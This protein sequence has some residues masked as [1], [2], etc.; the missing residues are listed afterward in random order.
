MQT[1]VG[2]FCDRLL[3]ASWLIAAVATPLFLSSYAPRAFDAPKTVLI[4]GLA[5]LML[6][7]WL[8]KKADAE[9]G[10][11]VAASP[12]LPISA[13][14]PVL[15]AVLLGT[16]YCAATITSIAPRLSLW[17]SYQRLQGTYTTLSYIVIFLLTAYHLRR[18]EQVQRLVTAI[19][20]SSLPVCFFGLAQ[21]FNLDPI[22]W[23]GEE[24][25]G[26]FSTLGHPL[27][28]AGYL[29]MVIPLTLEHLAQ[30][31]KNPVTDSFTR[32]RLIPAIALTLLLGLQ[33]T[34]F[35]LT[36]SRGPTLGLAAG[37]LVMFL[38]WAYT[39]GRRNLAFLTLG[40]GLEVFLLVILL[41]LPNTPFPGA[42]KT[43]ERLPYL[44]RI[45]RILET[46]GGSGGFRLVLWDSTVQLMASDPA[47]LALGY[48]PETYAITILPYY[49]QNLVSPSSERLP[50]RAHN[51]TF[52]ILT[53]TGLLGLLAHLLL[54]GGVFYYGVH[55][56]GIASTRHQRMALSGT[57]A[58]AV[59]AGGLGPRAITGGWGLSGLGVS[60]GL[61]AGCIF[62]LAVR[63]LT[64]RQPFP[65]LRSP[66]AFLSALLAAI[67]AHLIEISFGIAIP[68]TRLYFWLFAAAIVSPLYAVVRQEAPVQV[69]AATAQPRAANQRN[70]T[71]GGPPGLLDARPALATLLALALVTLAFGLVDPYQFNLAAHYF[72]L[73]LLILMTWITG[74]LMT[75][76]GVS[77]GLPLHNVQG[78]LLN[79]AKGHAGK[80]VWLNSAWL[81]WIIAGGLFLVYVVTQV[82]IY[83]AT[84]DV[85]VVLVHYVAWV[86]ML[87]PV[88]ALL[89]PEPVWPRGQTGSH[90]P[91]L[92]S[93]LAM[94]VF[95][96]GV[97][98][99]LRLIQADIYLTLGTLRAAAQD[100]NRSQED[101][102]RALTLAP[103]QSLYYQ[104]LAQMNLDR[105][106]AAA[107]PAEK[108]VWLQRGAGAIDRARTLN[109]LFVDQVYNSAQYYLVWA[110]LTRD[111]RLRQ[112][113]ADQAL[114]FCRQAAQ[115]FPANPDIYTT[116]G[117]AYQI[118]GDYD[119]ALAAYQHALK[120]NPGLAQPHLYIGNAYQQGGK[121]SEAIAAYQ[122]ALALDPKL[123]DARR[124]L[125]GLYLQQG[126]MPAA[127]EEAR[128]VVELAPDDFASHRDLA[129]IYQRAGQ[130][131]EALNEAT[132]AWNRAPA[133][134]R[135]A[136][137]E[138]IEALKARQP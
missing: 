75:T 71:P 61:V 73:P 6:L 128:R 120:L 40:I 60:L 34:T 84:Q 67:V 10:R 72:I 118:K 24:R 46:Q 5:L 52:D 28:L 107:D 87:V 23:T 91:A 126:N 81:P 131:D 119:Q 134:Q 105:A 9:M 62:F 96:A 121:V 68:T 137:A 88:V 31:V 57:M 17:G 104:R 47:R 29:I 18:S 69:P 77:S 74:G 59:V 58:F 125:A 14:P 103:D 133:D 95:I 98:A 36:Q 82:P 37:F 22:S 39:H 21:Q 86:L 63:A 13:P 123:I 135:P 78:K 56:L 101:F 4:R 16:V 83:L 79:A 50:D 90:W 2:I 93:S 43:I 124:G 136:L 116:C 25:V 129:I 27:Y 109:P 44:G 12:R 111:P 8:V 48:G 70:Q 35:I 66:P 127:L 55:R 20:L 110:Q 32:A 30:I 122:Q 114:G 138:L 85:A 1:R 64:S 80:P 33:L 117:L 97:W 113:R 19:L 65:T 92:T 42:Q 53:T 99:N 7:A 15:L 54:I 132:A 94:L 26:I 38:A 89:L 76:I 11:R 3:E 45:S 112:E 100:W 108:E 106:Q 130:L 115:M 51:E 102:H 49:P 41:N